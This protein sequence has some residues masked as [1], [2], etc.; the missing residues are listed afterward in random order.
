MTSPG[1]KLSTEK[2]IPRNLIAVLCERMENAIVIAQIQMSTEE[3][4]KQN[5]GV[6]IKVHAYIQICK[7]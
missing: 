3:M 7:C 2:E 6:E 4:K 1:G 5:K